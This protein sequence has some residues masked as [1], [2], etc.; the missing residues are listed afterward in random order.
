VKNARFRGFARMLSPQR[1]RRLVFVLVMAGAVAGVALGV[2]ASAARAMVVS[3][4]SKE[5]RPESEHARPTIPASA[6]SSWDAAHGFSPTNSQPG[7][8][9]TPVAPAGSE[10]AQS[11]DALNHFDQRLVADNGNQFS[12]EPPD[13]GLC[14][15]GTQVVEAVN[16]I[17]AIYDTSGTQSSG[18]ESL[19]QFF[20]GKHQINRNDTNANYT[21]GP[22]LSDPKCYYDTATSRW[23][24]TILEID[25][26]PTSGAMNGG[27]SE[28][29]AVSKTS[30]A[31]INP[32]G[33]YFYSIDTTN[34]GGTATKDS[35]GPA[36]TL[37]NHPGC[38]C[39]GDQ[40]LIGADAYG[41]YITTNEFP[42]TGPGFNGAQVYAFDKASLEAGTLKFQYVAGSTALSLAEGQS[43]SLQPATS[44]SAA[45][46]DL[47]NYGTEYL[48]SALDFNATF[49]NRIAVWALTNTQSLTTT[50]PSV[51]LQSAVLHSETYGQPSPAEQKGG[52]HPFGQVGAHAF[53]GGPRGQPINRLNTNDDRM[54]Q[55]VY[56]GGSLWSGVNT[57]E[58]EHNGIAWFKVRPSFYGNTLSGTITNQ[59]YVTVPEENVFFPSIGVTPGG[60]HAVMTMTLSG[61]D[62]YP[63]AAYS[64]FD[65]HGFHDVRVAGAG[66]GPADG[67][68]G[69]QP[70]AP[71]GVERWG[72]YSAAVSTPAGNVWIAT[73]YIN[74]RCNVAQYEA[75]TT[76]GGTR[77]ALANWGTRIAEITP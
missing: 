31:S 8:P 21:Y 52:P 23:F 22:F 41:F 12:L 53:Y 27:S 67:F 2:S 29:I 66:V 61:T 16:D 5:F 18:I 64:V 62:Y 68:T 76:C 35:G 14:T 75:D 56:A 26:D 36:R 37:P 51:H 63:S 74:Q 70:F 4:V 45:D 40:P 59:G 3:G 69:Y 72:D 47:S 58:G 38:P 73:E 19:T 39:F 28:L 43:Y 1:S 42:I 50:T 15:D 55:V 57:T 7:G 34:H 54:N 13:Q 9:A 10:L 65:G 77:S 44:P 6:T 71:D 25:Q 48:L 46:Y 30:T 20:T 11:F 32:S 24:M 17:F 49:D 33:W 60:G